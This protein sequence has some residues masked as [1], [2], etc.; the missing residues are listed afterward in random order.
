MNNLFLLSGFYLISV[1]VFLIA[2]YRLYQKSGFSF[3]LLFSLIYFITFYLGF[4]F[5]LAMALGFDYSLPNIE[6]Q[7]LVFITSGVGYLIYAVVYAYCCRFSMPSESK[8]ANFQAKMTACS[9]SLM[10]SK[11]FIR[12]FSNLFAFL[13]YKNR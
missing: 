10:I 9:K 5:S 7:W 6:H 4:P 12:V 3:H 1:G 13:F 2:L 8:S 11:R